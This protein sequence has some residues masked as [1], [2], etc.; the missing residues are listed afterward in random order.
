MPPSIRPTRT[1][2]RQQLLD[3]LR[4]VGLI[5]VLTAIANRGYAVKRLIGRL[6]GRSPI[7]AVYSRR[8]FAAETDMTSPTAGDVVDCL[9]NQFKPTS[10]V[11]LGCGTAV[12]LREFE[13]H[14]IEVC[15]LEGSSHAIADAKIHAG[16]IRQIDLTQPL[17][18][19]LANRQYDLV[20]SFEVAEHLPAA[21]ADTFVENVTRLGKTV[22]F[23]A[24]QPG[25]GGADHV[26]EQP[27]QY[28]IDLFE[29]R[30]FRHRPDRTQQLR[31]E[32]ARRNTVWWLQRNT[33]VLEAA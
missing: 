28:W 17:D 18:D 22:V 14:G 29:R 2:S 27:P 26:N 12:Y 32:L 6:L 13:R 19:P 23:S 16:C 20:I 9:M 4:A 21:K 5:R 1:N 30:G 3:S 11:D 33:I 24:A 7:D 10:V 25:Q 8:Y 31:D 15:G